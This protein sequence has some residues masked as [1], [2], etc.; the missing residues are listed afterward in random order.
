MP[1]YTFDC[2]ECGESKEFI[3]TYASYCRERETAF[4][5]LE[6]VACKRAG[7]LRRN[8]IVDMKTQYTEKQQFYDD[9]SPE[10][11]A[12]RGGYSRERKKLL[13]DAKL[14]EKGDAPR[15][16]SRQVTTYTVEEILAE[17][18]KKCDIPSIEAGKR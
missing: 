13:K 10:E 16:K 3:L 7:S 6:C 5:S 2:D 9:T 12:G 1:A 11:I 18:A 14:V 8:S 15:L 17:R 4:E